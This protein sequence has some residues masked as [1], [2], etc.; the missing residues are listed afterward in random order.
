MRREAVAAYK[1]GTTSPATARLPA[2]RANT[3]VPR[4]AFRVAERG[5]HILVSPAAELLGGTE[6][7]QVN[8]VALALIQAGAQNVLAVGAAALVAQQAVLLPTVR[9][10]KFNTD[11]Q[12]TVAGGAVGIGAT[13]VEGEALNAEIE[14]VARENV[15]G[16][17]GG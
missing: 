15:S 17:G 5:I 2:H 12:A 14:G 11:A 13:E 10:G 1:R 3:V 6:K 16:S 9:A 7:A 8:V 4:L